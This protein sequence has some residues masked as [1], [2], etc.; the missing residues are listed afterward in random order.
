LFCC[1][2]I[3]EGKWD[4]CFLSSKLIDLQWLGYRTS[5]G[6]VYDFL[7]GK[8]FLCF[9]P[10]PDHCSSLSSFVISVYQGFFLQGLEQPP[11]CM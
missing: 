5:R 4:Y 7:Q 11:T 2:W 3:M 9:P 10:S 8:R 1:S 6:S